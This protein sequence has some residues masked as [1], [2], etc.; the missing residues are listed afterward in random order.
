MAR[1]IHIY[2]PRKIPALLLPPRP[3]LTLDSGPNEYEELV[4]ELLAFLEKKARE[5]H[6]DAQP[7]H[8]FYGNQY[9]DVPLGPKP[10]S[11]KATVTKHAVHELLSS[12][13]PW[14]IDELASITGHQNKQT[15][16]SWMSMFKNEKTAGSKGKLDIVKLPNGMY[17][18]VKADGTPAPKAA[19]LKVEEP[20]VSPEQA[21][22]PKTTG[23]AGWKPTVPAAPLPKE[24]ANKVYADAL[25]AS[26]D[27]VSAMAAAF[28]DLNEKQI[29]GLAKGWK[30]NKAKAMA[31]WASN[32]KGTEPPGPLKEVEVFPED[33]QLIKDLAK[34]TGPEDQAAAISKWKSATAQA[35]QGKPAAQTAPPKAP[36]ASPAAAKVEPPATPPS[37]IPGSLEPPAEIVPP[38]H[39][40]IGAADFE[41]EPGK[42]A[43]AFVQKISDL[44]HALN[45]SAAGSAVDNKLFV[46]HRLTERLKA[47]PHF[48]SMQEQYAKKNSSLYGGSLPARLVGYWASSSGDHNFNSVSAQLAIRDAFSMDK[49][50]VETKAFH[51]LDS[52]SG[53]ENYVHRKAAAELG[54]DVSTPEKFESY[55]AGMRD[56]ALAQ[57]HETQDHFKKLGISEVH[58]V[59]G[60]GVG[61]S[62]SEAKKVKLK[63]Q[64]ASSFSTNFSTAHYFA[65]GHSVFLVKVPVSQVLG[66]FCSGYGCSSEH[67]VVVLN[68]PNMEAI[69]IG[70]GHA[71]SLTSAVAN[72]KKTGAAGAASGKAKKETNVSAKKATAFKPNVP[73][74]STSTKKLSS[75][76]KAEFLTPA[77]QAA[78]A[79]DLEELNKHM[80]AFEAHKVGKNLPASSAYMNSLKTAFHEQHALHM[81]KKS[82][83]QPTNLPPKP[84]G[85]TSTWA[86]EA[87]HAAKHGDIDKVDTL[88]HDL[89][90]AYPG[91]ESSASK[92]YLKE[93]S[94]ELHK[95]LAVHMK[96]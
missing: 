16:T 29:E 14:S 75:T 71:P 69:Q 27:H 66:S 52:A 65:K 82:G 73:S 37:E 81:A 92:K 42:S 36:E 68:H 15:L 77:Y 58:L 1:H 23:I 18:V 85:A 88:Y 3:R 34:A 95:Q 63:L 30:E 7:G 45:A 67:E 89:M 24:V 10:T 40:H 79:G 87:T 39:E 32:V 22:V 96:S 47:S 6:D 12:G 44:H 70:V 80:A 8:P 53:D 54:I 56:F 5:T 13:H 26:N 57:Y 31:Q 49:A 21:A 51:A 59:R 93:L 61:A 25:Q 19:P 35:K 48:Q 62:S 64:P 28:G 78:K 4:D 43:P 50:S 55:K 90:Q 60:M 9:T 38:G 84:I 2:L 33:K 91:K 41:T 46:Q 72:V 94:A 86:L 83:F 74:P 76:V 20:V 11:T 17:Q